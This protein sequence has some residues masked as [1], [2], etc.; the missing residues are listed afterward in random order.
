MKENMFDGSL[1]WKKIGIPFFRANA[2]LVKA[3]DFS[4][5]LFLSKVMKQMSSI[6]QT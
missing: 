2:I 3:S 6:A 5:G 4:S 1:N